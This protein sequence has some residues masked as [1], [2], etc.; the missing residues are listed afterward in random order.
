MQYGREHKFV[1]ASIRFI[2]ITGADANDAAFR[3]GKLYRLS[4]STTSA[5]STVPGAVI[6]RWGTGTA[7][8]ADAGGD[9]CLNAGESMIVRATSATM[10]AIGVGG[11]GATGSPICSEIDEG[12]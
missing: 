9:F 5:A 4:Y 8:A 6:C 7:V 12:P 1:A 3:I 11:A 2:A 10:H